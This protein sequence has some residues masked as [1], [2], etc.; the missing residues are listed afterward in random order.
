MQLDMSCLKQSF[1]KVLKKSPNLLIK[2]SA[3]LFNFTFLFQLLSLFKKVLNE[4]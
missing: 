1:T 3:S 2:I 4:L